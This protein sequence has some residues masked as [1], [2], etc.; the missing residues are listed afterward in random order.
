MLPWTQRDIL[1]KGKTLDGLRTA[2]LRKL[3]PD[4]KI[5]DNQKK[6]LRTMIDFLSEP[7]HKEFYK[8]LLQ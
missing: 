6:S 8:N 4:S 3:D 1:K 7:E 5:S 2:E